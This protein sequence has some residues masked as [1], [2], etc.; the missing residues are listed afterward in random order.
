MSPPA[1]ASPKEEALR[2]KEQG[3]ALYKDKHYAEA[4]DMFTKA[5]KVS[6][7]NTL[8]YS[9]RANAR[10]QLDRFESVIEDATQVGYIIQTECGLSPY[11]SLS[12]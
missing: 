6:P 9:N 8:L 4:I 10:Y 11:L 2:L 7:A 3:N 12:L 5:I 1:S